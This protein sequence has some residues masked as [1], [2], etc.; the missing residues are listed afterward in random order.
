MNALRRR[1]P[2]LGPCHRDIRQALDQ[3]QNLQGG[4]G[5]KTQSVVYGRVILQKQ[6]SSMPP[7][8]SPGARKCRLSTM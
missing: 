1:W 2:V 7:E 5:S 3:F 4:F 6:N 8:P